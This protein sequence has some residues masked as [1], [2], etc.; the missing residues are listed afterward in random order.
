MATQFNGQLMANVIYNAT[1]N[2]YELVATL[3]DQLKG[4]KSSVAEQ[5]REDAEIGRAHV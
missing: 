3:A 4:L 5:F 2:A 1:Y